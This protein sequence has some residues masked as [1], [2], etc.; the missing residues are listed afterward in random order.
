MTDNAEKR[1]RNAIQETSRLFGPRFMSEAQ[2]RLP[3][4]T[5]ETRNLNRLRIDNPGASFSNLKS[6]FFR[7]LESEENLKN[8][9][10]RQ[11]QKLNIE[12]SK[13]PIP[14]NRGD[15]DTE[16][17]VI[18]INNNMSQTTA[19]N[20]SSTKQQ[21]LINGQPI[22]K[23]RRFSDGY[24]SHSPSKADRRFSKNQVLVDLG[25]KFFQG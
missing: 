20:G 18:N 8:L 1:G 7:S 5:F 22:Q 3:T 12:A 2:L 9:P 11:N 16:D 24:N 17:T 4:T 25:P 15:K 14:Q 19:A 23:K 6:P 13:S 10:V 21:I